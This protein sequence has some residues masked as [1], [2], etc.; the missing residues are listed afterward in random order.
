[1]TETQIYWVR[2]CHRDNS[3][4]EID[5]GLTAKGRTQRKGLRKYFR[6]IAALQGKVRIL[7]SPKP[8]C[9]ETV[10]NLLGKKTPAI[11]VVRELD[12]QGSRESGR[13]FKKRVRLFCESTS[14]VG[15]GGTWIICSH[16]DWLPLAFEHFL[17]IRV[18]LKKGG[19]AWLKQSRGEVRI[20]E[21]RQRLP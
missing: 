11:Q 18:E 20:H 9:R 19:V 14:S 8:R 13:D 7:T 17:G 1:M 5:S 4:H 10:Q 3:V 21:L 16:G 2:H 6:E 12:E 15:T